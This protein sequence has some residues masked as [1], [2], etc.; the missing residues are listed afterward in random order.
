MNWFKTDDIRI[1]DIEPLISPAILIK[2]YPAT[3]EIAKMVATTRK[4]AENIIFGHDDR[5]LGGG[6][7]TACWWWWGHAPSMIPRLPWIMPLA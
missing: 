4:N 6:T 7:T 3:T 1:Q 5:L 2:D